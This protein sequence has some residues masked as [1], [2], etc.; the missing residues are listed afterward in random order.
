MSERQYGSRANQQPEE[1][2]AKKH[3][4]EN[5][6][7]ISSPAWNREA[8]I[9]TRGF[10]EMEAGY[11]LVTGKIRTA[12]IELGHET[13]K[14]VISPSTVSVQFDRAG[15]KV[16]ESMVLRR[17]SSSERRAPEA[18][19]GPFEARLEDEGWNC[20]RYKDKSRRFGTGQEFESFVGG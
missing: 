19:L 3:A 15:P 17:S 11:T 12:T 5:P 1:T 9:V 13:L 16:G 2:E 10:R 7:H 20:L 6:I 14:C 4:Q 8:E 18:P